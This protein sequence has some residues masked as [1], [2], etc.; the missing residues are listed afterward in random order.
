M[1]YITINAVISKVA[2]SKIYLKYF[3]SDKF[4]F[5]IINLVKAHYFQ[6]NIYITKC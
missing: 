3:D 1:S 5:Y 4:L 2:L 6:H